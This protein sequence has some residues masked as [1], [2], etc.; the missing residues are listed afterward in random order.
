MIGNALTTSIGIAASS[1]PAAS[2]AIFPSPP[3]CA[4]TITKWMLCG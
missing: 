3:T 2:V 1:L 4:D